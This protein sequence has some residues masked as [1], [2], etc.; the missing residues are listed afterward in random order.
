MDHTN[1]I[2]ADHIAGI[3]DIYRTLVEEL[4]LPVALYVGAEM[5]VTQVNNSLLKVWGK[6][7]DVIGKTFREA[8]PELEG[9]PFYDIL[10]E[11]YASGIPYQAT[12]DR[13]DL[14][15]DG[16]MQTFYFNFTYKPL[17]N[18]D[19]KVWGILN[20]ATDVTELIL[21]RKK[22]EEAQENSELALKAA[23]LGTWVL[24]PNDRYVNFDV[25]GRELFGYSE[26]E[27]PTLQDTLKIVHPDDKNDVERSIDNA[28]NP[29]SD[30]AYDVKFRTI[31]KQQYLRC[32]GKAY[33][34]KDGNIFRFAGTV[35]DITEDV[36]SQKELTKFLALVENSQDLIGMTDMDGNVIYMNKAGQNLVGATHPVD[37]FRPSTDFLVED[38]LVRLSP[39]MKEGL[40][41]DGCYSGE[42]RY[43]HLQTGEAIPCYMNAFIITDPTTNEPLGMASVTR[44]LRPEQSRQKEQQ[45]LITLVENCKDLM[46]ILEPDGINSYLNKAGR[47]LLGF[48]SDDEVKATPIANLHAPEDIAFVEREV[49]PSIQNQGSWAGVMNVRHL[50]TGEVF[51][52][53]NSTIRIDDPLTGQPVCIGAIMRDLRP[54][55]S[56]KQELAEREKLFRDITTASP[57]ALWMTGTNT[58]LTYINQ[59]WIDWTNTPLEEQ[60]GFGWTKFVADEDKQRIKKTFDLDFELRRPHECQYRLIDANGRERWIIC[61]GNPQY[62][63]DG[64]FTGYIGTSVDITELKQLQQQKDEFLGI[65]SHELKTPV[66]SIKAY[67][68]VLESMFRDSG[69]DRKADMVK[70]MDAQVNRLTNLIGDLLDVTKIQTGKLQFNDSEFDFNSLVKELTEDLQRTTKKHHI[71]QEFAETGSVFADKERIGQVITN[72]I[73]NAIKYSPNADKIVVFTRREQN[74]IRLCVQDFGIGIPKDKKDKVFEQFYRVSGDKQHTFPGLG[75]GLYISSEIIKREGGKIWVN[76]IEGEGS[77]FCFSL[78]INLNQTK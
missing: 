46:S 76:S 30:H 9:Q 2:S 77:T 13:V 15:I 34:D 38:D 56:A 71:V 70:K 10:D 51:P 26:F 78:P 32:V 63:V 27:T 20:T 42:I 45:K 36:L 57:A 62:K 47:D 17:K 41:T 61:S 67:A 54:E 8:L 73:T 59:V 33:A 7:P 28:F 44:D 24:D 39:G 50:K 64:T 49:L 72:L 25:R 16:R 23:N 18:K 74:E 75:L 58:E 11:V 4:P 6:G 43:K 1:S 37:Y 14:F 31:N 22:L 53:F 19:G 29:A 5:R 21:T 68:Q 3:E 48:E 60:L 52:V 55:F 69:D 40:E 66:T 65:A 12:E 35:E